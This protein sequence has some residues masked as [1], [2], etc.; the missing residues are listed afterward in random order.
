MAK[1]R[2]TGE[3][4]RRQIVRVATSLF[5]KRGFRGTTTRE[6]ARKA[7]ISE[8]VIFRHFSRKE[9]GRASCRE[10]V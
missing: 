3:A 10:R 2:M 8:A 7:G 1:K 6:I 5:V 4:R 9:I